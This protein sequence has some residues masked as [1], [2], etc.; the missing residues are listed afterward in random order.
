VG[1]ILAGLA[2]AQATVS[3]VQTVVVMPFEDRSNA[4][5]LEW[6]SEA[7]PEI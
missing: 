3:P 1:W 5:G 2:V 6:I 4:P 7:F